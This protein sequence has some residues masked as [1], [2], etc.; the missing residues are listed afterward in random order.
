MYR[1]V[2]IL[3]TLAATFS[4]GCHLS[5]IDTQ[6]LESGFQEDPLSQ[7][8]LAA[9]EAELN[10]DL[11]RSN[12]E[13]SPEVLLVSEHSADASS[14]RNRWQFNDRSIHTIL[15]QIDALS[16]SGLDDMEEE[17]GGENERVVSH[18]GKDYL[19]AL[20]RRD[21]LSGWNA[22][23]LLAQRDPQNITAVADILE[24]LV[25]VPPYYDP[26]SKQRVDDPN[27]IALLNPNNLERSDASQGD[28]SQDRNDESSQEKNDFSESDSLPEQSKRPSAE[29]IAKELSARSTSQEEQTANDE[30]SET[31]SLRDRI[32]D[33]T[34][35][36]TKK[37]Q[38]KQQDKK[39]NKKPLQISEAMRA[40]AAE[41][42]CQFLARTSGDP[43]DGLAPAGELLLNGEHQEE[44]QNS[45]AAQILGHSGQGRLTDSARAELYLGISHFV[46]PGNIPT[47][48]AVFREI[49]DES[50]V[51]VPLRRAALDS[52]LIYAYSLKIRN[53]SMSS[54]TLGSGTD[55]DTIEF[56]ESDWPVGIMNLQ[57]DP[58]SSLRKRFG[59]W[60][61]IIRHPQAY[62]VLASQLLDVDFNVR[63]AALLNLGK[64]KTP[65]AQALLKLQA[66]RSEDL[67][68]SWAVRGLA[69]WGPSQVKPFVEDK[70]FLVRKAVAEQLASHPE[71]ASTLLIRKL[72]IDSNTQVQL[73]A[74]AAIADWSDALALPLLL[75]GLRESSSA[76]RIKCFSQLRKKTN[77]QTQFP[78]NAGHAEREDATYQLARELNLPVSHL[79]QLL[80]DGL[81]NRPRQVSELQVV[82]MKS[83]LVALS[84]QPPNSPLHSSA[85]SRLMQLTRV[86]LPAIEK[87]LRELPPPHSERIYSELLPAISP[88]YAALHEMEHQDILMRR[89]GIQNLA[90]LVTQASLTQLASQ[91]LREL[92]LHEQDRLI[93]RYA[94]QAIKNDPTEE[95]DQIALLAL[96]HMWSDI[97]ILGCQYIDR[98]G[99]PQYAVWMLGL[100][101]FND[102]S[103][104]VK[105]A[106]V[107]A[108]G[109]CRN[110]IVLDGL[111]HPV[112]LQGVTRKDRQGPTGGLR[113]LLNDPNQRIRFAATISMTRLGD[114]QGTQEFIRMSFQ[115]EPALREQVVEQMGLTGRT[116][117]V[118][119]L[120]RMG[121]TESSLP[122]KRAIL[123]S[124]DQ[125][126]PPEKRPAGPADV[127]GPDARIKRWSEWW[128]SQQ[129]PLPLVRNGMTSG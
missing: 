111:Q 83:Q 118:E 24:G 89:K 122:V 79:D 34:A 87:I 55:A 65:E 57:F 22:A 31:K 113:P 93:W 92:L 37:K 102:S 106:A 123:R 3:M 30:S 98:H 112:S 64:L 36:F 41:A 77:L 100:D 58:E 25:S 69:N 15:K 51:S 72:L 28:D 50:R 8:L 108:A 82:E 61:V 27:L 52:C 9:L 56:V 48:N 19:A 44:N 104:E 11:W 18:Q 86:E 80:T 68:R 126:V 84:S 1:F 115:Q 54:K 21:S 107:E 53:R 29:D 75:H 70:S 128:Q 46:A 10:Q 109:K 39:Q 62:D 59:E 33:K 96:N 114:S 85:F 117:F 67:I 116:L 76:T 42:W 101:L 71:V 78:L 81:G 12:R 6:I 124:L 74:V 7:D 43:L 90:G 2:L 73:A 60:L 35:N 26:D 105:L 47:L 20:I 17:N 129:Q 38:D 94:M 127:T 40:A 99:K 49:D 23:I 4:S 45:A 91:R 5:N 66:Q 97:R 121:W 88:V 13:W 120:I 63:D 14:Q 110:P 95:N 16:P 125:L 119:H 103:K 32:R